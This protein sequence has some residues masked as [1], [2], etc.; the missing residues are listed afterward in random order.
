MAMDGQQELHGNEGGAVHG[1]VTRLALRIVAGIALGQRGEKGPARD[2]LTALLAA[3][4]RSGEPEMFAELQSECR[5]RRISAER[6]IDVYIPAAVALLGETWHNDSMNILEAT[7]AFCRMQD[8]LREIGS[9]CAAD[10]S[11]RVDGP[12]VLM[13]VPQGEQHTI[14]ALVATNQ[15][16]RLG[17]SVALIFMAG[18]DD[19]LVAL[20]QQDF[21]AVFISFANR[22]AVA[23]CE[24]IVGS[25][26]RAGHAGLP[27]AVGGPTVAQYA[28]AVKR[29]GADVATHSVQD[30]LMS[31]GLLVRSEAAQ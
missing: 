16:R 12:R 5:R 28:E 22:D 8:L 25:I 23:T 17:V 21:D 11:G 7:V 31:C 27:V 29:I 19:V 18:P 10:R 15:M 9:A 3:A 30:A 2:D 4:A 20:N 14:S 13:V 26:R 1:A 24:R 6:V